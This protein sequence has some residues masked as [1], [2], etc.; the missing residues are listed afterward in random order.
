[1]TLLGYALH[2]P[3]ALFLGSTLMRGRLQGIGARREASEPIVPAHQVSD[4][5]LPA[6][7]TKPGQLAVSLRT[8]LVSMHGGATIVHETLSLLYTG[9][10]SELAT[11]SAKQLIFG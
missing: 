11:I 4:Q 6:L 10:V 8:W 1:M 7:P 5:Q 3:E 9:F 2:K